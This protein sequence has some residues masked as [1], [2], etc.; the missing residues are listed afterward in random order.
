MSKAII[1]SLKLSGSF[2][3]MESFYSLTTKNTKT[4]IISNK[5]N[6]TRNGFTEFMIIDKN[7]EHYSMNNSLWFLKWDSIEDWHKLKENDKINISYYG[8]RVPYFGLFPNI[9]D[10]KHI[11]NI[12]D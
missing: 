1:V 12:K 9:I 4:I 8:Y 10:T 6:F 2:F 3:L 5:Y 7:G 11:N